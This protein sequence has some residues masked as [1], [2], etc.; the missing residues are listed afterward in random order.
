MT[1]ASDG[2]CAIVPASRISV[3][4]STTPS[5]WTEKLASCKAIAR[6][7]ARVVRNPRELARLT[8]AHP[9]ELERQYEL[10]ARDLFGTL[11]RAVPIDA[12]VGQDLGKLDVFSFLDDTSTV[13]DLLLLR[14]LARRRPGCRYFEIGTFRGES[15]IAVADQASEVVTLS[16]SD[17]YLLSLGADLSFVTAHRVFSDQNP[18]IR[19]IFGDSRTFDVTPFLDWAD[20]LFI[21]GD[22]ARQAVE[23]DTRRFLPIVRRGHGVV[24]WHDAFLS[25]LRPRWEV[26]AGIGAALDTDQRKSLVH[27]ANTLT[28]ALMPSA[29]SLP[30][31][32]LSYVPKTVFSVAVTARQVDSKR[33]STHDHP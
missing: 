19:H 1:G 14:G 29:E 33:I 23:T 4:P 27:V 22:H 2:L 10:E 8:I 17:D 11:P 15:A 7:A 24:V 20:V 30:T 31:I 25:P 3:N 16:L 13:L 28:V 21:D 6:G 9:E 32:E 26:L 12:V 18:K 5:F